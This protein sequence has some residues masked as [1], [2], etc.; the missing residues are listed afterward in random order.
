MVVHQGGE[1]QGRGF[2]LPRQGISTPQVRA[3]VVLGLPASLLAV[4]YPWRESSNRSGH[5]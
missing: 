4:Q 5:P 3:I 2:E 1:D